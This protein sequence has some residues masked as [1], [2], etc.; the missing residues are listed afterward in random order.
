MKQQRIRIIMG[1]VLAVVMITIVFSL[2]SL[3]ARAEG[4][5]TAV[6]KENYMSDNQYAAL[7]FGSLKAALLL[8]TSCNTVKT[9]PS[10]TSC[11]SG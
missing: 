6:T 3:V 9:V 10:S 7:G 5:T 8:Y 11:K 1:L 2:C 4:N